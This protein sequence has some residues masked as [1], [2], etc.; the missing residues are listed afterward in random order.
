LSSTVPRRCRSTQDTAA[1]AAAAAEI[2]LI[3]NATAYNTSVVKL[4]TQQMKRS[5]MSDTSIRAWSEGC[6]SPGAS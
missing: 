4:S 2:L 1:A 5:S 6:A 3:D